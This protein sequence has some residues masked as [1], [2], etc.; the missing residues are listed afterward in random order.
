MP[1][2]DDNKIED[3][4]PVEPLEPSIM[5]YFK[6]SASTLGIRVI[7]KT[8]EEAEKVFDELYLKYQHLTV[9]PD[10]GVKL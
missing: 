3:S 10:K 1:I 6:E 8:K 7:Q 4:I 2:N 5:L 9:K